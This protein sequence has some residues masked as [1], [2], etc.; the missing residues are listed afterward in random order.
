MSK[1]RTAEHQR[2]ADSEAR[3]ADW[4]NWGPYL[5]ERAWGTV[6]EDYSATG[7]AWD[8]FPHDHARSRAYRWNEDGLGGVSN[9]LQNICLAVAL[10]NGRDP[11]L[12]ERL[13]GLTGREGNHGEDVKEVYF[14]LDSTPTHSYMKML[15]KYPQ[16]AYPYAE[17]VAE[18]RRRSYDDPEFELTDALR[19]AFTAGR[20]FD[21]C[22]E[23]AKADE[24]DIFYRVT[25]INRGPEAAP[26]HVLPHLW[27]RNTW[28]WGYNATRPT[29]RAAGAG[30]V[31]VEERHLGTRWSA[32]DADVPLLFTENDTN[33]ERLFG[34]PNATPC[35]KDGIHEAVV[36]GRMEKVNPAQSGT[37]VAAHFQAIVQPGES[38]T[39][40]TRLSPTR[41][42]DPF[43]TCEAV[44]AQR[45]AEAD[46]F[47]AAIQ[48]AHLTGDA[49]QVQRQALAG[50][51]WSKQFYHYSVELWLAGDPAQPPPPAARKH[52]RNIEWQHL[53]NL[54]VLSMPDKWEFP[55]FAAWDL[56]F[57]TLPIALIDPEW[58][59]RQIILLLREW[60]MHPNGQLPAYEWNF[61]DVN[62]PVH[63]WAA[64]EVYQLTGSQDTN[65]LEKVFHKLLLNF[66][67]WVNRKD[68]DGHNVFQGGFLGLD[69]IGVFDRSHR[70]PT[71]G[72][73]DQA[74]GTGWM[75]F[76][77]L[78]MLRI[79]LE[80][81]RVKPAYED[82]ATKFFEHFIHIA[83][84]FYNMG[85]RKISLWDEQDGLFYDVLHTPD[86]RFIPLRLHSLV[87]LIPLLAVMTLEPEHLEALPHF[88]RRV[89]WFIQ[90]RPHLAAHV[91]PLNQ[92]GAHEDYELAI[93]GREQ[94]S[95][96][97]AR[98]F[99][100]AEFL[101]DY[102]VRSLSRIHAAQPFR[103]HVDGQTYTVAY[104]PAESR[105][106]L[107]GGNSNWRGP[108]W[109]PTNY[110][111]IE[112]LRQYHHHY[113]DTL[114]I[115]VPTGS[116]NRMTLAQAAD[117]LTRRLTRIFLRD[118][119]HNNDRPVFGD[120]A[121]FQRDPHWQD[122]ILF[123]EYFHGDTGA[124]LGASHQT[125]WTALVANLLQQGT[126]SK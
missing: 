32:A 102:G 89:E 46:E 42:D 59:K 85:G 41:Q 73:I 76:Y 38:F 114:T 48:P 66:T 65:F 33:A 87:S 60:Y 72:R 71:G 47:Y 93:I 111:L 54:D 95:R 124:G 68:A 22:I 13:F 2:L 7:E 19:E 12:K 53:Y 43:A 64:W 107:F 10:W 44:F 126:G 23:I 86:D 45:I 56:A 80:L 119:Q 61:S 29:L 120:E 26:L 90:Y 108:V 21:V 84:A 63:A 14:Y 99:D 98:V 88:R 118:P 1:S 20:Y 109:F 82:I 75:A 79:A 96:I 6:R 37:K 50:L 8:Y 83:N 28:S 57:H 117:E 115:E 52:G 39:V 94:L 97:L 105:S 35:V 69:N 15:Y 123:H 55:W 110:L 24:E 11:I 70:L 34:A 49:R 106:G 16:V 17:L 81:A 104:E 31:R 91:A 67:W 121:L 18:N 40:R 112:A 5:S 125:G 77:C 62:P 9:R 122:Y 36:H 51:M 58:A 3:R 113:G 25:A 103:F 27:C 74:D 78:K 4:K 92:L 116:G 100:P 101:S 30:T